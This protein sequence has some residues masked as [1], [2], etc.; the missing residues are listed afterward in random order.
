M[1]EDFSQ[2]F[3]DFN[4]EL[5]VIE[6]ELNTVLQKAKDFSKRAEKIKDEDERQLVLL[7]YAMMFQK[8]ASRL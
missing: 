7:T 3:A 8:L 5:K 1:P 4:K 2:E 6:D